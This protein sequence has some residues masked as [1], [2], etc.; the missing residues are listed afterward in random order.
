MYCTYILYHVSMR[1][2]PILGILYGMRA[3]KP[4]SS[5]TASSTFASWR[6]SLSSAMPGDE[7]PPPKGALHPFYTVTNIQNK[8]RVLDGV[9]FTYSSRVKHFKLHAR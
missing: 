1:R 7:P 4:Q 5:V 8:F 2:Q 6:P 3:P 9:K